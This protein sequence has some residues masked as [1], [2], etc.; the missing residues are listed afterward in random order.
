MSFRARK[1]V[2]EA[3]EKRDFGPVHPKPWHEIQLTKLQFFG[4]KHIPSPQE[5]A[6][7]LD[8]YFL[9][10]KDED[11]APPFR[12]KRQ[13]FNYFDVVYIIDSSSS[14]SEL[15]FNRGVQAL[16]QMVGKSK[17]ASR[18]GVITIATTGNIVLN[19][20]AKENAGQKLRMLKRSG[21]KTNTQDALE[22]CYQMFENPKYGARDGSFKRILIVTDGQSNIKKHL[23]IEKAIRLKQVGIEVF[24]IAVGEYLDG[25]EELSKMA[26]SPNAHMYRVE[27]MNGLVL[28]VKLI[29]RSLTQWSSNILG[30]SPV[31][32]SKR[33]GA[34]DGAG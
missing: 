23:T 2:F 11:H 3:F 12:N 4:L 32:P 5:T 29:P 8:R 25:M 16:E 20:T 26:S 33:G 1:L 10:P 30:G 34:L 19:F 27:D 24:V 17:A 18:H 7:K 9:N 15:E 22:M 28:V 21:G 6:A 14:I 13:L 31:R